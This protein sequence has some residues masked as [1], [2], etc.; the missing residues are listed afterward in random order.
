MVKTI[1]N[2]YIKYSIKILFRS[3]IIDPLAPE[4]KYL[5]KY[6]KKLHRLLLLVVGYEYSHRD[7]KLL[8]N[9]IQDIR[10]LIISIHA[11]ALI[12]EVEST[13]GTGDKPTEET[14]EEVSAPN[15]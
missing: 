11:E 10:E 1:K 9:N 14:N 3:D 2:V 15:S 8:N 5:T 12:T 13:E 7:H 6:V 4:F